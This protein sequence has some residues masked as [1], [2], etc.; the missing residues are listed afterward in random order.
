MTM[1]HLGLGRELDKAK[2]AAIVAIG[3]EPANEMILG[4]LR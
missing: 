4:L 2:G 3:I 1:E